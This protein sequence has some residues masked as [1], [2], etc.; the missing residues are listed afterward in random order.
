MLSD[1]SSRGG[2]WKFVCFIHFS[3]IVL[4]CQNISSWC[5]K[6]RDDFYARKIFDYPRNIDVINFSTD[7]TLAVC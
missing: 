7:L 4:L 1:L 2:K 3:I 5:T 6:K